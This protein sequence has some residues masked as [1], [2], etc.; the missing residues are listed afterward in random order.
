MA[1][2]KKKVEDIANGEIT[3]KGLQEKLSKELDIPGSIVDTI[4]D[5]YW[6]IVLDH[7][8]KNHRVVIRNIVSFTPKYIH[9]FTIMNKMGEPFELEGRI[10]VYVKQGQLVRDARKAII[11]EL[12]PEE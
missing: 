12:K 7:I 8:S 2:V 10:S 5:K 9:P 1:S 11:N 4:I 3:S 6:E